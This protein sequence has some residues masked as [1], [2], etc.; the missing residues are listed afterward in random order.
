MDS[1]KIAR[2]RLFR[3]VRVMRSFAGVG[4]FAAAAATAL[5]DPVTI[6]P[7]GKILTFDVDEADYPESAP[8]DYTATWD[9]VAGTVTNLIKR[10]T[11]S[12]MLGTDTT[13]SAFRGAI[14]VEANG[15]FLMGWKSRFGN[16]TTVTVKNGGALEFTE[17]SASSSGNVQTAQ[18]SF[19][20]TQFYV[21]GPGPDGHGALQRPNAYHCSAMDFFKYITLTGDTTINLGSRWGIQNGTLD[22]GGHTLTFKKEKHGAKYTELFSPIFN[23]RDTV[24]I[25]NP[26]EIVVESGRLSFE[27]TST[28]LVDAPGS[29][30]TISNMVIRIKD[31][32]VLRLFST[33]DG[34]VPCKLVTEGTATIQTF[35]KDVSDANREKYSV[36]DGPIQMTG[37]I[38]NLTLY[39]DN[40]AATNAS[41]IFDGPITS[42]GALMHECRGYVFMRGTNDHV[43]GSMRQTATGTWVLKDSTALHLCNSTNETESWVGGTDSA[44]PATLIVKDSAQLTCLPGDKLHSALAIGGLSGKTSNYGIMK[45]YDNAVVSNDVSFG[46]YGKGACYLFGGKLTMISGYRANNVCFI[47]QQGSSYGYLGIDGGVFAENHWFYLGSSCPGFIVQRAGQANYCLSNNGCPMRVGQH[48]TASYGHLAQLGGTSTWKGYVAMN[49]RNYPPEAMDATAVVTV[50]GT[51]TL[52]DMPNHY[53]RAVASTNAAKHVTALVNINDGGRLKTQYIDRGLVYAKGLTPDWA[54]VSNWVAAGT[55]AY[56]NFNGGVL[57]TSRAGNF[58]NPTSSV[59]VDDV[60]RRFTRATVYEK[61]LTIDTDGKNVTWFQPLLKPYGHGIKSITLPDAACATNALIGPSRCFITSSAGGA[62]ADALMDF[63]DTNR[64]ARGMI[65]TSRGFGYEASPTVK[66]HQANAS[67]T[68]NC[69][70][71]TVDFDDA[72]FAHGGLTKR[73]TG[74]LTLAC[75]NTY[76]GATRLEGGTLAFTHAQ[77]YPGGDL[78]IAA[79][80]VQGQTLAAPLLT[81]NTLAFSAGTGV[82]VTEADTLDD[83]T[84]G[85]MKTVAT[86]TNPILLPSLTLVDA[87]GTEWA[88]ARQWCLQ[89]ADGGRT[90]KF[91]AARGTQILFR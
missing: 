46:R 75:T 76:A 11:G 67:S 9:S 65:I 44:N 68:W 12:V 42:T 73:G 64:V 55:H 8:F 48:G 22:M 74:T 4:L 15:G 18:G 34:A 56:I 69:A 70:V 90:L 63:D 61:G 10:G 39:E 21:E 17:E 31:G 38:V 26:G 47:G 32:A 79:A 2:T 62:G 53:I 80:A 25:K 60:P 84:F 1:L 20:N 19:A 66:V 16:P 37:P 28:K 14:T 36:Y 78:E 91:G 81:A 49:L 54:T 3:G 85:K 5:A 50:S 71:E 29:T 57:I 52:M 41:L 35:N 89:L 30:G 43:I 86:F 58:W 24:T 7:T 87:D 40:A 13:I 83:K 23:P 51:N 33:S 77:G 45:M 72:S 6:D 82:R 59:T 27:G 88:N